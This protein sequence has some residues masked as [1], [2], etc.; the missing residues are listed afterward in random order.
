MKKRKPL[1]FAAMPGLSRCQYCG[2]TNDLIMA[3]SL[4]RR[5]HLNSTVFVC[6]DCFPTFFLRV[7]AGLTRGDVALADTT[8]DGSR[9]T[10]LDSHHT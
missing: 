9:G 6:H 8:H 1:D 4:N 10:E 2:A 7:K 3:G 5:T